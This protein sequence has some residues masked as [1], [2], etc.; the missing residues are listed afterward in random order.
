MDWVL[1][2]LITGSI[3]TEVSDF[4]KV[5][6]KPQSVVTCSAYDVAYTYKK[7]ICGW[8]KFPKKADTPKSGDLITS[9]KRKEH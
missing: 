9:R 8:A 3:L 5:R 4:F 1:V 7:T 2:S 6:E